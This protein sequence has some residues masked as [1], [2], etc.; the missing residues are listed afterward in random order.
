[1]DLPDGTF[2]TLN[3]NKAV[4]VHFSATERRVRLLRGEAL[5]TVARNPARPFV[6]EAGGVA[7]KAVG[8]AFNVR[9]QAET[10]EVLVTEGKVRVDDARQGRSLLASPE[11]AAEPASGGDESRRL[12]RPGEKVVI[13][14][15][16]DAAPIPGT[17]ST[18]S[19]SEV[20]EALAWQR[21][22][23]EYVDAPLSEI[24]ADFNR[25]NQHRLVIADPALA[26]SRF[27]GTFP[28]GD[29]H[30]LVQLLEKSF[31]VKV[32]RRDRETVLRLP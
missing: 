11:P 26:S 15:R 20:A 3:T 25:Y 9:L 2:V 6:V 30:S 14:V 23:L 21:R 7:V 13:P 1:M 5:F 17:A 24:I 4:D 27:G 8:T 29:Y 22:R 19:D 32:E 28:A 12:L 16:S 18:L 10:V 31:G